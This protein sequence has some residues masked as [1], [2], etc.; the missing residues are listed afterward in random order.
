M[1]Y[2]RLLTSQFQVFSLLDVP[3]FNLLSSA[4]ETES[5]VKTHVHT[6]PSYGELLRYLP[7]YGCHVV[8]I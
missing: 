6:F 3:C 2:P 4:W 7:S 1:I 8:P 5:V